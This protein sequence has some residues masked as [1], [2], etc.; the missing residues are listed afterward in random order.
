VN[1]LERGER[2][3]SFF[4]IYI[5]GLGNFGWISFELKMIYV[6]CL[7]MIVR[8]YSYLSSPQARVRSD[9]M[10]DLSLAER[11]AEKAPRLL[12]RHTL[13]T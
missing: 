4:V 9:C 8:Q 2:L 11:V 6:A 7:E 12:A 5:F 1:I 10:T 3:I 13:E